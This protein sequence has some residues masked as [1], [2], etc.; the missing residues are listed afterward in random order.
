MHPL[1]SLHRSRCLAAHLYQVQSVTHNRTSTKLL[2]QESWLGPMHG[3]C[4]ALLC[5]LIFSVADLGA[6]SADN[7]TTHTG[8]ALQAACTGAECLAAGPAAADQQQALPQ[9]AADASSAGCIEVAGNLTAVQQPSCHQVA[10]DSGRPPGDGPLGQPAR[11]Q[12]AAPQEAFLSSGGDAGP[13]SAAGAAAAA[14]EQPVQLIPPTP[15]P[16]VPAAEQPPP[17]PPREPEEALP[18][19]ELRNFALIKDGEHNVHKC[20]HAGY[21]VAA[22]GWAGPAGSACRSELL[23]GRNQHCR[24]YGDWSDSA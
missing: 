23:P 5:L 20:P 18:E 12:P 21:S 11:A 14:E 10:E 2:L 16:P 22:P 4:C 3:L 13:A 6:A 19:V 1:P 9:Q 17:P 24:I 15:E 7:L 8:A